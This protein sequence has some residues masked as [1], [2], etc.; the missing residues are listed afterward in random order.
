MKNLILLILFIIIFPLF[1]FTQEI[2]QDVIAS[3]G[4]Y[5]E[6]TSARLSWTL[7]ELVIE[8][9]SSGEVTLTQGFHQPA[10]EISSVFENSAGNFAMQVYPVQSSGFIMVEFEEIHQNLQVELYNLEGQMVLSRLMDSEKITL[11]LT[12]LL[13]SEY[14]LKIFDTG[15]DLLRTYK[16][17]K[18]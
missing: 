14:I 16:I 13:P 12:N 6:G 3:S 7:G 1:I 5:Y 10:F 2:S 4:D 8:T 15:N 9:H 11:D 17:V 18:Y